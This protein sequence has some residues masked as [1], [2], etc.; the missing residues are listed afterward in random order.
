MN[1]ISNE[2]IL[3]HKG[4]TL[5]YVQIAEAIAQKIDN[6]EWECGYMLPSINV[7]SEKYNV[8]RATAE[9]AYNLLKQQGYI[10][11]VGGKGYFVENRQTRKPKILFIFNKISSFKNIIYYSFLEQ[12]GDQAIV[13]MQIHHYNP[14]VLN[15]ILDNSLGKYN[16]YV[17]MPHFEEG[18]SPES[19]KQILRRIPSESLILLDKW[20]DDCGTEQGV[21][22]NF[23]EDIYNA[24]NEAKTLIGKYKKMVLVFPEHRNHPS[25]IIQGVQQFVLE[26]KKEFSL[27]SKSNQIELEKKTLYLALFDEDLAKLIKKSK[28]DNFKLGKDIGILSFNE[29][30]LKEVLDISVVSTDF[31]LMGRA[32]ASLILSRK[33][34]KIQNPFTLI[35]RKSL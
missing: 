14:L 8:A 7:F 11:A 20:I 6:E 10:N 18:A 34:A 31:N 27:C 17:I 3:Q 16:Y 29:T 9:K 5:L 30:E 13:D 12:L 23:K 32:A 19:Y 21:Y 25:E 24:L 4:Q 35:K 15:S 33:P 28:Q 1:T 22:Q 2:I 26:N